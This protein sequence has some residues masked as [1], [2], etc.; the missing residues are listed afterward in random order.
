[1]GKK[2][3]VQSQTA[4]LEL[5]SDHHPQVFGKTLIWNLDK[6]NGASKSGNKLAKGLE[7]EAFAIAQKINE[8]KIDSGMLQELPHGEQNKFIAAI[9]KYLNPKQTLE[10]HYARNGSHEFGNLTFTCKN[11]S[12]PAPVSTEDRQ[13]QAAVSK[14]QKKYDANEAT[15][16]QVLFGLG[17]GPDGKKRLLVNVH[18][19]SNKSTYVNKNGVTVKRIN[20]EEVMK[21]VDA[22]S[23]K[24]NVGFVVGG[25]M[26]AGEHQLPKDL[27]SA[28]NSPNFRYQHSAKNSSFRRDGT[29]VNVDAIISTD[30][31]TPLKTFSEMNC[32]D[33]AF[34]KKF[35][36]VKK[37]QNK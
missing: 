17:V 14:L 23:K 1:M 5:H 21:E 36:E 24:H 9:E 25:D 31:T 13:L 22:V 37:K 20:L 29:A 2:I 4:P 33:E 30:K 3:S 28:I 34:I 27:G 32:C 8:G 11:A 7:M 10:M 35:D 26:N 19:E 18:A 15:R 6:D 12:A 16:G